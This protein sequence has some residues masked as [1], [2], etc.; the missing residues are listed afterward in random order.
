MI[1]ITRCLFFDTH[2]SQSFRI[3]LPLKKGGG[4]GGGGERVNSC[5]KLV[6]FA[7]SQVDFLQDLVFSMANDCLC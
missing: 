2:T 7:G 1:V 4:G 6:L 5:L 3:I